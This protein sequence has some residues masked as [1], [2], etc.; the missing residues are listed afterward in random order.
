MFWT[1]WQAP[2][3]CEL[4]LFFLISFAFDL[5][6]YITSEERPKEGDAPTT[7]DDSTMD[8]KVFAVQLYF[9]RLQVSN[10]KSF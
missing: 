6:W 3:P 5:L 1:N 2:S 10:L 4:I 9:N 7:Q 8:D